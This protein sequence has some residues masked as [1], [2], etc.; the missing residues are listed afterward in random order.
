M[1][2]QEIFF[3]ESKAG[4]PKLTVK[5]LITSEY[6]GKKDKDYSSTVGENILENFSLQEQ[7][8]WNLNSLYKKAT[9]ERLPTGD[10]QPEEFVGLLKEKLIGYSTQCRVEDDTGSGEIRSTVVERK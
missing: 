6:T 4:A 7:A 9:G 10:Y 2:I 5:W 1:T 8:L 3:G